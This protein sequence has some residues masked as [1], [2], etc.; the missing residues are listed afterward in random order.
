[1]AID[2]KIYGPFE[3]PVQYG[4]GSAKHIDKEQAAEFIELLEDEGVADKEG[5]YVFALQAGRGFTPWYVGKTTKSMRQEC[6]GLHQ[7]SH[8]NPVLFKGLKG[9]PVM[10]IIAPEGNKRD[11]SESVCDDIETFLIQYAIL[12]NPDIRNVQKTRVP[13]WSIDGVIRSK[14][15]KPTNIALAFKTMMA[16]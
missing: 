10:F 2:L 14:K 12:K 4:A 3:I 11:V 6:I 7:R 15:G 9:T 8:Y 13:E 5:C 1:V 16:I